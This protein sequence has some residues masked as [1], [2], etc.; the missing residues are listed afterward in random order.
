MAESQDYHDFGEQSELNIMYMCFFQR[1]E[2]I[3]LQYVQLG[4][5]KIKQN[6][7]IN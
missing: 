3:I 6:E 1:L 4:Q 5:G 7:I 2:H